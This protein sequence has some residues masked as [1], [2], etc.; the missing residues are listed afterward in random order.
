MSVELSHPVA[1]PLSL[2]DD[3][4][5]LP[6]HF[7]SLARDLESPLDYIQSVGDRI[8]ACGIPTDAI[9][10][11]IDFYTQQ[12]E[13]NLSKF[14]ATLKT[15]GLQNGPS[16]EVKN[17]NIHW[18]TTWRTAS[19]EKTD[20]LRLR[21]GFNLP[22]L[23]FQLSQL[24]QN[25]KGD[26]QKPSS[27]VPLQLF[28]PTLGLHDELLDY[29]LQSAQNNEDSCLDLARKAFE[30]AEENKHYS[31]L[32]M[33][34][35]GNS[36]SKHRDHDFMKET[37]PAGSILLLRREWLSMKPRSP[38]TESDAGKRGIFIALGSNLGDRL[39]QLES[40]CGLMAKEGIK[41]L[42]TSGLYETKPMYM[43]DQGQ[44]LNGV[45]EVGSDGVSYIS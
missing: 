18:T 16:W 38:T 2:L 10:V 6:R 8:C 24:S 41:L 9:A 30:L 15:T 26:V 12:L 28:H 7:Q 11:Q 20:F 37:K 34:I 4:S 43:E 27:K 14:N 3:T 17:L 25:I 22:S 44:F 36:L 1:D 21:S 45:C 35:I 13:T 42:R 33:V 32:D 23:N 29:Y 31:D 5:Q 40:A 39:N 19:D